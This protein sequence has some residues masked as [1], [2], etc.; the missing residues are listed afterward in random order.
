LKNKLLSKKKISKRR[1][2]QMG[3]RGEGSRGLTKFAEVIS[4]SF[5]GSEV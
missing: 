5:I 3:G 2:L 1:S 4:I